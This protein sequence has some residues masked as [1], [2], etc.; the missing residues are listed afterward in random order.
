MKTL[1]FVFDAELGQQLADAVKELVAAD[2]AIGTKPVYINGCLIKPNLL[3][4]LDKA[5]CSY[6]ELHIGPDGFGSS[7]AGFKKAWRAFSKTEKSSIVYCLILLLAQKRLTLCYPVAA[8]DE[9]P[10]F[11][12]GNEEMEA[13]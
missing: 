5:F 8:H 1:L 13:A 11:N 2:A 3:D 4:R 9:L 6:E 7:A 10:D 12:A